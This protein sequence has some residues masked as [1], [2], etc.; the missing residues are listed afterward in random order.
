MAIVLSA[1]E[2]TAIVAVGGVTEAIIIIMMANARIA[3]AVAVAVVIMLEVRK[4]QIGQ[5]LNYYFTDLQELD[6][7]SRQERYCIKVGTT[8][9]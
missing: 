8:M 3:V 9:G 7:S 2:G 5:I 6:V 4:S 1:G